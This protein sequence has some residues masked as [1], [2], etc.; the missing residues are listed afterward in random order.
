MVV[1]VNKKIT[2]NKKKVDDF[3]SKVKGIIVTYLFGKPDAALEFFE[4]ATS[5]NLDTNSVI[6]HEGKQYVKRK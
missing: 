1:K 2:N 4:G 6:I 3:A 5:R